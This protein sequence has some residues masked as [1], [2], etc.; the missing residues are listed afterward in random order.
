[1]FKDCRNSS[2][3][4]YEGYGAYFLD[5]I[6][7][8]IWRLE[9]MPDAIWVKDPFEKT[10]LDKEVSIILWKEWLISINLPNLGENFTITGLNKGNNILQHNYN[11]NK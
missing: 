5:Y 3:I 8:G 9:V 11:R 1:M 4:S 2:I 6:K 10:S 7:D